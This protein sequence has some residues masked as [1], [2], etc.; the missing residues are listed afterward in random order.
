MQGVRLHGREA[1]TNGDSRG[2][3]RAMGHRDTV[4]RAQRRYYWQAL[5][6]IAVVLGG[7]GW[8]LSRFAKAYM[9][10]PTQ[11]VVGVG[12]FALLVGAVGGALLLHRA[13]VRCPVCRRWLVPGGVNGFTPSTCRHCH[14]DLST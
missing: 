2:T 10:T 4:R 8:G 11:W 1:L 14:T 12:A 13:N 7:G 5:L 6:W 9:D 3:L